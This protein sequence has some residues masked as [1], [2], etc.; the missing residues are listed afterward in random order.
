LQLSKDLTPKGEWVIRATGVSSTKYLVFIERK[1]SALVVS[2]VL[3]LLLSIFPPET[4]GESMAVCSALIALLALMAW[5][6][7]ESGVGRL[8][9]VVAAAVAIP[10]AMS[11]KAPAASL[12]PLAA[13]FMAAAAGLAA[14]GLRQ[15]RSLLQAAAG[16]IALS[17][18]LLSLHAIYQKLWGLE[19]LAGLLAANNAIPDYEQLLGRI[20]TGRAYATFST[21][22]G[23]G[24]FLALALPATLGLAL[25]GS[26]KKR[27]FWF[28]LGALQ[29]GGFLCAASATALAA[30]LGAI[31]LTILFWSAGRRAGW[32]GLAAAG[33]ILIGVVALRGE[34]LLSSSHR[35][36]P[37]RLRA[38]NFRAAWSMALD[39]PLKGVGPGSFAE[40]YPAYRRPGDNEIRH[41]HNLPLEMAAE[42]GWIGGLLASALFFF[43]FLR[44][45]LRKRA[46]KISPESGVAVGLAA[47]ALHN[48][49]DYTAF[50]PSLLWIAALLCG[51]CWN[52][53]NGSAA[54]PGSAGQRVVSGVSLAIV[55][56]AALLAG[57][58]GPARD[59]RLSARAA[60]FAGDSFNAMLFADR[61]ASWAPW[62]GDA[63]LLLARTMLDD[64]P[65]PDAS[66]AR[67]RLA[68]ELADR[69]VRLTPTRAAARE[70]RA[71][72]RA[73][74]GDYAGAYAD[75]T[76]ASRLYPMN[77][78]YAI[79]RET[80]GRLIAEA[81]GRA[82][83]GR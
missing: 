54:R 16:T 43:F 70:H 52:S 39:H 58:S 48:L 59:C 45:L 36:S 74:L 4:R 72:V 60:A 13:L 76:E 24:C 19:R 38:G 30:L 20:E 68:L 21:P 47:F 2:L 77:E 61:A 71:M 28:V 25:A 31:A 50:M 6:E 33:L 62:D 37:W 57:V 79:N 51:L 44:P 22:A 7:A 82:G 29:A 42:F 23:F 3:L 73:A 41:V 63:A 14:A 27:I 65:L 8:V 64:P 1:Q 69:A 26:G 55:V 75:F 49:A 15:R 78:E 5:R 67:Q 66:E 35:N 80:L 17:A 34:E 40:N 53:G 56:T 81:I 32:I 83:S 9:M 11:A 46:E 12:I 10:A 18:G